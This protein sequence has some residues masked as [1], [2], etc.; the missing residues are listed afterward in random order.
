MALPVFAEYM[1]RV[2]ADTLET[3]IYPVNF[4]I[5]QSVDDILDCG[6]SI[7]G[8]NNDEYEEEF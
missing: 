8:G 7:Q 2:Y 4:D 3:G 1:Q 5:P 6:E